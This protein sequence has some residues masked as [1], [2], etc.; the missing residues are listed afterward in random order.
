MTR[1][2]V[3]NTITSWAQV[4]RVQSYAHNENLPCCAVQHGETR[5]PTRHFLHSIQSVSKAPT[6]GRVDLPA[7]MA[8]Q[9]WEVRATPR[10]HVTGDAVTSYHADIA[11][12]A[13]LQI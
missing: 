10:Q 11:L 5:K 13:L 9:R 3:T 6:K 4:S 1:S 8:A 2:E 12:P 7:R